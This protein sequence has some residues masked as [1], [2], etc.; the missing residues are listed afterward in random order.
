MMMKNVIYLKQHTIKRMLSVIFK[1]W[2]WVDSL[3]I[4]R[5]LLVVL[6]DANVIY[7]KQHTMGVPRWSW[8]DLKHVL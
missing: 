5:S 8:G 7:L 6:N 3:K 1:S 4:N 2:T